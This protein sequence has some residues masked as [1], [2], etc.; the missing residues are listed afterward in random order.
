M[1]VCSRPSLA[2]QGAERFTAERL[3]GRVAGIRS[4]LCCAWDSWTTQNTRLSSTRCDIAVSGRGGRR[5][6]V[7]CAFVDGGVFFN[8]F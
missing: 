8:I 7:S 2:R 5:F 1:C 4:T 6:A 3:V